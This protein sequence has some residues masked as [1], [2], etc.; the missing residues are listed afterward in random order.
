MRGAALGL[1][2]AAGRSGGDVVVAKMRGTARCRGEIELVVAAVVARS[3]AQRSWREARLP[4]R[5][6]V[7]LRA[8]G[9]W[10]S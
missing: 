7:E 2:V 1:R 10:V 6:A 3:E 8:P 9:S 4:G 5:A